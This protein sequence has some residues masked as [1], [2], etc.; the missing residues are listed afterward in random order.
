LRL[1]ATADRSLCLCENKK[2]IA[3]KVAKTQSLRK[4]GYAPLPEN[5]PPLPVVAEKKIQELDVYAL[6]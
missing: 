2:L 6:G 5:N 3:R 1:S 4:A